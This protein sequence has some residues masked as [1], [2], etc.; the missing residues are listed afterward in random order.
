M[1]SRQFLFLLAGC[2][3]IAAFLVTYVIMR[4]PN[5]APAHPPAEAAPS[6]PA[7]P[8][9]THP[10]APEASAPVT[11]SLETAA[12]GPFEVGGVVDLALPGEVAGT[13]MVL[14]GRPIVKVEAVQGN[15]PPWRL[16][17]ELEPEQ[18]KLL[19]RVEN[20]KNI[21]IRPPMPN[22]RPG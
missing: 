2:T 15:G 11:R 12:A 3:G 13:E 14:R 8:A 10:I 1:N 16:T 21:E 17:I 5:P 6:L 9:P 7:P 19:D 20:P 18:A 4:P 22:H